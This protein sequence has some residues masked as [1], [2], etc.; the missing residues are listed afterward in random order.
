MIWNYFLPFCKLCKKLV[1]LM[2]SQG[3]IFAFISVALGDC[4]EKT[5]VRLMSENVLP[6]FSS[7]SLMVSC[8]I[9]KSLSHFGF[10][11]VHDVRVCSSFTDLHA[12]VQVS[13]QYLLKRLSYSHFILLPPLS[14][15]ID[16][17]CLGLFLGSLFCSTGLCVCFGT[18][19][20]LSW[21]LWLCNIAWHLGELCLL[22][23]FCSSGLLWQ[24]WVFCGSI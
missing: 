1:S 11:F 6:M 5:F 3:L 7:R 2:R 16:H 12:A 17:R 24:F 20:T 23:G 22:L 18:S 15:L 13:Q 9:L 4:P 10:I 14:R 21:W 19:T 8:L